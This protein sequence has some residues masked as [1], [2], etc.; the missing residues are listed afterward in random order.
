[1]TKIFAFDV[2]QNSA[3]LWWFRSRRNRERKPRRRK[4]LIRKRRIQPGKHR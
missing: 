2:G 4:K 3:I 1:M